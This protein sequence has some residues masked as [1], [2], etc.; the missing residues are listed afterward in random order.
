MVRARKSLGQHFLTD[1]NLLAKIASASE[2]GPEDVVLE[3]GPGMGGLTEALLDRGA[4]VVAIERDARVGAGLMSRFRERPFALIEGDALE[5]NWVQ[6]VAPWVKTGKRWRVVGNIPY[7]I[8]SPLLEKALTPP[9]AASV[10]YLVQREVAERIVATAGS[11]NYG[12]LTVGVSVVANA[13]LVFNIGRGSFRPPPNVDSSLIHL[14]PREE[15]LIAAVQVI[16]LRRLVVSLFS[17]R[18]KQMVRALREAR[19]LSADSA[20]ALLASAGID[21]DVR[22]EVVTPAQFVRLLEVIQKLEPGSK[23]G[24]ASPPGS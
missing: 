16:P 9:W 3:I 2:A 13:N 6:L 10:T 17:F 4:T 5:L 11:K 20:L 22:P 24:F 7:F 23:S 14:V 18:R 21:P 19:H 15:P 1:R 8:T 12:A